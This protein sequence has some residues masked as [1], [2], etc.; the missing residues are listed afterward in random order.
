MLFEASGK[1]VGLDWVLLTKTGTSAAAKDG[2]SGGFGWISAWPSRSEGS[3][4][5]EGE[6]LGG[7]DGAGDG[8]VSGLMTRSAIVTDD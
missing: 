8:E 5:S 3:A 1:G 7:G 4:G 2:I 6:L